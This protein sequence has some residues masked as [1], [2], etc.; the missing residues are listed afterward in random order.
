MST[1]KVI[2]RRAASSVPAELARKWRVLPYRARAG[3]LYVAGPELPSD[4]M[5]DELERCCRLQLR[6]QLVTPTDFRELAREYLK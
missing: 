3:Q 2:T 5:T 1:S 6:F 4:E